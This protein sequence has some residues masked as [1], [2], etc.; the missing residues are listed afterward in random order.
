MSLYLY[1]LDLSH[2]ISSHSLTHSLASS[3][4]GFP[5]ANLTN[6]PFTP[7]PT[8]THPHPMHMR[9][10]LHTTARLK[11]QASPERGGKKQKKTLMQCSAVPPATQIQIQIQ[12]KKRREEKRPSF[13]PIPSH[14]SGGVRS[15]PSTSTTTT[16]TTASA[17][18]VGV[19]EGGKRQSL[20]S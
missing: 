4:A 6:V 16:T 11:N 3:L 9:A 14:P 19:G 2:L 5:T 20:C 7:T 13:H 1:F 8:P 12:R 18:K 10:S 15:A 17:I